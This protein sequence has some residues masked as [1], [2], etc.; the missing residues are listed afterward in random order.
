MRGRNTQPP[1]GNEMLIVLPL[2]RFRKYSPSVFFKVCCVVDTERKY[3]IPSY[4]PI[5]I[6]SCMYFIDKG[7]HRLYFI[8]WFI[9][10]GGSGMFIPDPDFYPSRI[11]DPGSRIQ[12]VTKER[13]EKKFV[14]IIF[15]VVTNF[16]KLNFMLF[17]KW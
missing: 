15:F 1:A 2:Y 12:I 6:P 5:R 11:S 17:L 13:G 16:T 9:Q 4:R 14:I 8:L 7:N 3:R 10:C